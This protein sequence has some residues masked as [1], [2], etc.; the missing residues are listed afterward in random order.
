MT[1]A[2]ATFREQGHE[3]QVEGIPIPSVTQVLTLAGIDDVS[4]IPF[5]NL[6]RARVILYRGTVEDGK[7]DVSSSAP[8]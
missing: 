4:K 2:T 5:H 1:A 8:F 3:Y 6:E 7:G